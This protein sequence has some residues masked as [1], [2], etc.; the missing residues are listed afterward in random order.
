MWQF[1]IFFYPM[2]LVAF[3]SAESSASGLD[4]WYDPKADQPTK[5]LLRNLKDEFLILPSNYLFFLSLSS[6]W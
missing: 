6:F 3:M 2:K 1:S 4:V 5:I